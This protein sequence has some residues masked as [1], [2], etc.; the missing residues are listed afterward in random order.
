MFKSHPIPH[1]P[2]YDAF[3]CSFMLINDHEERELIEL[4]QSTINGFS[5]GVGTFIQIL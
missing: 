3:D 4:W 2:Q 1:K 5:S